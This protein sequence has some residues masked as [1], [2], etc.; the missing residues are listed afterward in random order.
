MGVKNSGSH[1]FNMSTMFPAMQSIST[2]TVAIREQTNELELIINKIKNSGIMDS[3]RAESYV[4]TLR[5][6][7]KFAGKMRDACEKSH[8]QVSAVC[9]KF[10]MEINT[11]HSD[12]AAQEA[13]DRQKRTTNK[14]LSGK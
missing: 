1:S 13:L 11:A 4:A 12:T 7:Q 9:A 5:E 10:R 14:K 2:Q 3:P 8:A 6:V